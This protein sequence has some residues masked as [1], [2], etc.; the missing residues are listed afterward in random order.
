MNYSYNFIQMALAIVLSPMLIGIIRKTKAFFAGRKGTPLLQTYRDLFKLMNKGVVYSNSVTWIFRI[1]P[2]INLAVM[3]L[4]TAWMPF[5]GHAGLISFEGDFIVLIYLMGLARFFTFLAA[6]D[7]ASSFE[8]MGVSREGFFSIFAEPAILLGFGALI[9]LPEKTSYWNVIN[10]ISIGN[11]FEFGVLVV[12]VSVS[13]IIL[14]VAENGRIPVDDP[15]THLELTMLHEVMILD[16]SGP[17][18]AMIEYSSSLKLWFFFT[19]ISNLALPIF[20]YGILF[21]TLISLVFVFILSVIVGIIE[22]SMARL[23]LIRVPQLLG[24]SLAMSLVAILFKEIL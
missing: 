2:V 13:F 6:M 20:N 15:T 16:N 7:T 21:H 19:L 5:G 22:S 4:V 9:I 1:A 12:L 11:N 17:D 14:S 24:I 3:L 10:S 8:G 23:R 18:L